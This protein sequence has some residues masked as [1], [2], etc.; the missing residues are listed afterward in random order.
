MTTGKIRVVIDTNVWL[1]GLVF[2]GQPK[3]LIRLFIEDTISVVISE[4]L[5]SELRRK[6]VQKFPLY[7]PNVDLLELSLRQDANLIKLG[8]Q[9]VNASRDPDDNK[10][11]ETALIGQ[12]HYIVSGDKDL[13]V[14]KNFAG[15]TILKPTDLINIIATKN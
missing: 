4:E 10:V 13:L 7:I 2:G 1:S 8:S 3:E 9:T 6:I 12:C 5:I 11:I 14:L 15:I